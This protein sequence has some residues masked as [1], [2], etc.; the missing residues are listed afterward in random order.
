VK[1]ASGSEPGLPKLPPGIFSTL[2]W[3]SQFMHNCASYCWTPMF[4][5]QISNRHLLPLPGDSLAQIR[6][7][8]LLWTFEIT[9]EAV[10]SGKRPNWRQPVNCSLRKTS[11][12]LTD[13][14]TILWACVIDKFT[15]C[16]GV[17]SRCMSLKRYLVSS[18]SKC[19]IWSIQ[20]SA[21]NVEFDKRWSEQGQE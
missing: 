14:H 10:I 19:C 12:P 5:A 13:C 15:A 20:P 6:A 9:R 7:G 17:Y 18:L 4:H 8:P 2:P 16:F 3:L 11:W 1:Q 21:N